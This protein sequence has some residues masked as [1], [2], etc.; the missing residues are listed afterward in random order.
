[1][2]VVGA[3][4]ALGAGLLVSTGCRSSDT[5][6]I[7]ALSFDGRTYVESDDTAD[8]V[9]LEPDDLG[10]LAMKVARTNC[11]GQ[12]R[13]GDATTLTVGTSIYFV[14]SEPDMLAVADGPA[15]V[16]FVVS[17]LPVRK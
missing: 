12:L 10:S 2:R 1:M 7:D 3:L 9:T 6:C 11:G 5:D 4:V 15:I 14:L 16:A 17:D 8:P 13:D